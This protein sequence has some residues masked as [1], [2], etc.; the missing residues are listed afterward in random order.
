MELFVIMFCSL[1]MI[2]HPW[3]LLGRGPKKPSPSQGDRTGRTLR[4]D[5]GPAFEHS[6]Q[7]MMVG[8]SQPCMA[9]VVK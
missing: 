5:S 7:L 9:L 6:L 4:K 8:S 3:R 1:F 2:I